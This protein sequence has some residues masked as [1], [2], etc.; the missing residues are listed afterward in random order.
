MRISD[1]SS[2]VCSSDLHVHVAVPGKSV[3]GFADWTNDSGFCP[4]AL[5][6][7]GAD[8]M[9]CIVKAG[10]EEVVHGRVNDDEWLRRAL[11]HPDD[12]RPQGACIADDHPAG[13]EQQPDAPVR[14]SAE[15]RVGQECVSTVRFRGSAYR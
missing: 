5:G 4:L 3:A 9:P 15:R 14:T 1:W 11:L 13:L 6:F 2:D 7:D 10:P 8:I 12:L